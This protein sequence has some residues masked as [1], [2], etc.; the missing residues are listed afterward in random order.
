MVSFFNDILINNAGISG[1]LPQNAADSFIFS[2]WKSPGS[3]ANN[4]L[5]IINLPKVPGGQLVNSPT[6]QSL[7][8]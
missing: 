3:N 8:P 1:T 2:R 5:L 4:Q 6:A 7:E